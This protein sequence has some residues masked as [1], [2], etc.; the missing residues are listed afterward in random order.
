MQKINIGQFIFFIISIGFLFVLSCKS[1]TENEPP[2]L[3]EKNLS[4]SQHIRPIFL[5]YCA[6]APGCHRSQDQAGGL[7]LESPFPN[8]L[9][10]SGQ[11]VIPEDPQHSLLFQL[12]LGQV[13]SIPRMPLNRPPLSEAYIRAIETWISEGAKVNN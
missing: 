2:P 7:D 9:S 12:L 3:P 13:G 10:N 5:D 4:Y 6:S 1:G 8:F 11:V